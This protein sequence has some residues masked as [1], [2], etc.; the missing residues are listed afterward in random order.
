MLHQL[1]PFYHILHT[2]IL[3]SFPIYH[4]LFSHHV[5]ISLDVFSTLKRYQKRST[6][7][8]KTTKG[9]LPTVC[10]QS[11]DFLKDKLVIEPSD[12]R[13]AASTSSRDTESRVSNRF[14]CPSVA[15]AAI[16]VGER[17]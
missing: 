11:L 9:A 4:D 7:F 14:K 15:R 3:N 6:Q 5:Y 17:A 12:D 1:F 16:R 10:S 2:H 8:Y 13:R